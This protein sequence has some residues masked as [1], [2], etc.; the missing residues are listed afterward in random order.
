MTTASLTERELLSQPDAWRALAVRFSNQEEYPDVDLSS[1]SGILF[2]GSGSSYYLASILADSCSRRLGI[3]AHALPSGELLL[4]ANPLGDDQ[5]LAVAISRSGESTEVLRATELLKQ[6]GCTTLALTCRAEGALASLAQHRLLASEG[7]EQG[8]VML[9]SFT[10]MHLAFQLLLG[11]QAGAGQSGR[12]LVESVARTGARMLQDQRRPIAA[13]AR[14]R[15]FNRFVFLGSG[16]AFPLA[17]EA[18]LKIQEM[19]VTTSEAYHSLEYRHGPISTA[20]DRTLVTLFAPADDLNASA[21]EPQ[22]Q[23]SNEYGIDLVRDLKSYGC[24]VLV[25]AENASAYMERPNQQRADLTVELASDIGGDERVPLY[26][27]PCQL[28]ALETTL[29][30]GRNP[31]TSRN[32]NQVVKF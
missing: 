8:L 24:A 1:Y 25:V 28:L 11:D 4:G 26:L 31:D 13:L 6:R 5:G 3:P 19:A 9:R 10:S 23:V 18:A 17:K 2:Y 29:H 7:D 16:F 12:A 32:L 30:H 27:L 15:Q 21:A 22:R 20:D 14:Q